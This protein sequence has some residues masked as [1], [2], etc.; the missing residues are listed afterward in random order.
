MPKV[1][2][3]IYLLSVLVPLPAREFSVMAYNVNNFFDI[4]GISGFRDFRQSGNKTYAYSARKLLTKIKNMAIVLKTVN[5]GNGPDIILFQEF[6]YDRTPESSISSY[7][8]FLETYAKVSV[9]EMLTSQLNKTIAGL[10]VEALVLKYLSDSGMG[11]YQIAMP[12]GRLDFEESVPHVNVIF[13]RFPIVKTQIHSLKKAREIVEVLIE[14]EGHL[15]YVFNNHWKSNLRGIERTEPYRL[16]SAAILRKRIDQI[17]SV[18]PSADIIVGGDLN[19]QYNQTQVHDMIRKSGINDVLRA[20]GDEASMLGTAAG[21]LYNLWYE[22]SRKE[23]FS[24]S[25]QDHFGTLMHMILSQGLYDYNGVQ[26]IDHSFQVVRVSDLNADKRWKV[27]LKPWIS[28]ET[29]GGYSDHFPLLARFKTVG[30]ADTAHFLKLENPGKETPE[31]AQP[32]S[33][34]YDRLTVDN[35][36][37]AQV[38]TR[39]SRRKLSKYYNEMFHVTAKY[40]KGTTSVLIGSNQFKLYSHKR[41][42]KAMIKLLPS[43]KE[44]SFFGKLA[45]YKGNLEFIIDHS[46]WIEER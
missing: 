5:Q 35:T 12:T 10:P 46:S 42:L 32:I 30:D 34:G 13:S 24:D 20:K 44:F 23:R 38:L 8:V 11:G 36:M 14:I 15:L 17:L 31:D 41:K 45:E 18:N 43:K 1:V 33:I 16:Q 39:L 7:D 9:N 2:L 37:D 21:R 22:L 27:P 29:G 3:F 19:S 6:E 4:D 26:Y 25:Y 28:G 40:D